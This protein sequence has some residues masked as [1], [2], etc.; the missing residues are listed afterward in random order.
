[1]IVSGMLRALTYEVLTVDRAVDALAMTLEGGCGVDL[2]MTELHMPDMYGL[3]LLD[4]IRRTSKL[5]VV[6]MSADSN[7]DVMLKSLRRGA[8]YYLVK[9]VL[10]EDVTNFGSVESF[11]E[12]DESDGDGDGDGDEYSATWSGLC[13]N[14]IEDE[15]LIPPPQPWLPPPP[16]EQGT[17][18][19][20]EAET[21]DDHEGSDMA[22]GGDQLF[23]K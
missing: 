21:E 9:P 17:D 16:Q 2:V 10:M 13:T 19:K 12:E 8:E 14:P 23:P 22:K 6:I 18:K 3:D 5:P 4:E 20:S 11:E 15:Q 1:M 7:E